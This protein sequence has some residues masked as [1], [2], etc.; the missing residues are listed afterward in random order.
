M[1]THIVCVIYSTNNIFSVSGHLR[2]VHRMISNDIEHYAQG[3]R[4]IVVSVLQVSPSPIFQSV[5][6]LRPTVSEIHE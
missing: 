6:L 3:Q 5:S 4:Y 1:C 2:H